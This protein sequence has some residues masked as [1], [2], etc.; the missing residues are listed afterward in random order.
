MRVGI[1]SINFY[2][3][4]A[5]VDIRDIFNTRKLDMSRFENLMLEKKSVGAP[6]EDPVSNAVNAAK[7]LI[8]NM[9]QDE[10]SRIELVIT[11]SES[12]IDFGKSMSTYIHDYLG[13]S[14]NCRLFEVKQA[15]FGGTAAFMTAAEFVA[16]QASPGAKALVCATDSP[17]TTVRGTYVEPSQSV[18][19]IAMIV[20]ENPEILELDFGA[21]GCSSYEVMDTCRPTSDIE[22]GDPDLSLLSYLDCLNSS[23]MEYAAKVEDADFQK[24]FDYLAFH[25][26]FAGMVKGGHRKMMRDLVHASNDQI[27]RDFEK[28]VLPSLKYCM[29][30]GNIYSATVYLALCGIID[31]VNLEDAARLGIFSY[32][33]GCS[34]E[35]YSGIITK[36]SQKCLAKMKIGERL[37]ARYALNMEEYDHLLDLN[38]Q[39]T[40]GLQDKKADIN[41]FPK[42]YERFF[43]G[44]GFLVLDRIK[45]FHR[46]YRWS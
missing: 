3:G 34:S 29:Q 21:F 7:P 8:D 11:S 24:T 44:R 5:C 35:F 41:E 27:N 20:G 9:S 42:L 18:G 14:R 26:P 10:K 16:S 40:F 37:N 2:G 39:W 31:S 38:A 19:A 23:F 15:C 43:E 25:T 28:R 36:D 45:G 22:T 32:G 12:G 17:K 30:V 4:P 13:L 33:S 6:W 1:E 46:E